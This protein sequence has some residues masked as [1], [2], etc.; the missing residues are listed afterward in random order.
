M[1]W[2]LIVRLCVCT[3]LFSVGGIYL[4]LYADTAQLTPLLYSLS[5]YTIGSY[6]FAEILRRGLGFGTVLA[7]M[8]ELIAMV[9]VGVL[10]FGERLGAAQYAGLACAFSAMAL[11]ALPHNSG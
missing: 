11:F 10:L 2:G 3:G 9:I 4:K 6:L 5:A 7:T 8:M 1:D